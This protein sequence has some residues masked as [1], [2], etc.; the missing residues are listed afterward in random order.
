[1]E[2]N[3]MIVKANISLLYKPTFDLNMNDQKR[4]NKLL[5]LVFEFAK[6]YLQKKGSIP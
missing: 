6:F 3:L 4:L 1:M 2:S 5:F